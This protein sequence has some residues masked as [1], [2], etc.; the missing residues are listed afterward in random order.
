MSFQQLSI[1]IS[2]ESVAITTQHLPGWFP[3]RRQKVRRQTRYSYTPRQIQWC[4]RSRLYHLVKQ[5]DDRTRRGR[6][7]GLLKWS[8]IRVFEVLLFKFCNRQTGECYP[9][10]ETIAAAAGI[11]RRTVAI[12]L[13]RLEM[14]GLLERVNLGK[15]NERGELEQTSNGYRLGP[16]GAIDLLVAADTTYREALNDLTAEWNRAIAERQEIDAAGAE[17]GASHTYEPCEPGFATEVERRD[18]FNAL[19]VSQIDDPKLKAA[20]ARF[21]DAVRERRAA[22]QATYGKNNQRNQ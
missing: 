5:F 10:Y 18:Y 4:L 19:A 7:Q 9:S 2:N 21:H 8:G 15:R 6:A 11:G 1:G 20:L 14:C 3:R 22:M 12:A 13:K 16:Y 17:A